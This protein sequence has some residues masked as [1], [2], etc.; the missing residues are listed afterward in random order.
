MNWF[1]RLVTVTAIAAALL[2]NSHAAPEWSDYA[3]GRSRTLQ[4]ASRNAKVL[5]SL[6]PEST[7]LQFTNL[8][9]IE[10]HLTNQ[11]LLN[12]SGVAAGDVDGDGWCDVFFAGLAGNG[13]LYR[14]L[15]NWKFED[16]TDRIA[17]LPAGLEMSGVCLV[18]ADGDGDLD[19][20]VNSVGGGTW[21]LA[22][23]G[24]GRFQPFDVRLN[25]RRGGSSLAFGDIDGD[26][27]LDGYIANYRTVTIRDQ[28]NTR[29]SLREVQGRQQVVSV[30]GVPVSDPE[31]ANRFNFQI[32]A[33]GGRG[34]FAYDENGEADVLLRNDG[35]GHFVPVPFTGGAF[36][37]EAGRPL[38]APLFDW[39]LS[40]AFRDL[41]GD[42]APDLYVCN[43]FRSPD[44]LW[45]ND[46]QGRFRA[47][48]ALMLR[49]ISLSSMGVDFADV[50]RDGWDDFL[51]VDMLSRLHQHRFSQR[52]DIRPEMVGPGVIDQRMQYPRNTMFLGRGDGSFVQVA[53][54]SGLDATEWS[55]APV[56]LDVDLDGYEDLLVSNG[57]E[58]DGM[59]VDVLREIELAKRE[60]KMTSLEQLSLRRKFPRLA[61]ANL[62]F[63]NAGGGRFADVSAEWGFDAA[64][65]SQGMCLAD[66]D[67]D[68]DLDVL[69]N[70]MNAPALFYRNNAAGP[71][72]AVRLKGLAP[73]TRGIGARLKVTGGPVVQTQEMMSG[74]RYLSS[75]DAV[76]T[77]AAGAAPLRIEVTWRSGRT[78]VADGVKPNSICEI[79][80]PSASAQVP[81]SAVTPPEPLFVDASALLNHSHVEEPFDDFARQPT[82]SR[83]LSQ[84]GPGVCWTDLDGDG[85]DDLVIGSGRGGRAAVFR[86]NGKGRFERDSGELFSRPVVRD[87][88]GIV[89]WR[90]GSNRTDVLIGV[91]NYEDGSTNGAAVELYN[92]ANR[93][94][95]EAVPLSSS[96]AGPLALADVDG[97]GELDLFVGGR[98][99]PDGFPKAAVSA[100]FRRVDGRLDRDTVNA[101]VLGE[102]GMVSAAVF[103][104]LDNDG[105]PDL[106]LACDWGPLKV[107][108]NERGS[109]APWDAPVVVS[110]NG[111]RSALSKLTGWWNGV[112]TGDFDGDGRQDIIASNWGRNTPFEAFRAPS[113]Q[114]YHGVF[115]TDE[116]EQCI[117]AYAEPGTGRALPSW[118][119]PCR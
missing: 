1:R 12:G 97:N 104:D 46:G 24:R 76:R 33:E 83:R 21:L 90:T 31:L 62:A 32:T 43:D 2:T 35:G 93:S 118:A 7:G 59:N 111:Q 100:L 53:H 74:G 116:A 75:D 86:N 23:D 66:L 39:G 26:G 63:H 81:P 107:F 80:E 95:H 57:F 22:N 19:L 69:V 51:V 85:W 112:T 9:S 20:A 64:A 41:N 56:F 58:R 115:G 3:W 14:N 84:L 34:N 49:Q 89:A 101:V 96:S 61:T 98:V 29:F 47:A 71:R 48:P 65:V 6:A 54:M 13:R 50:N 52:I 37:D 99:V 4:V 110:T 94:M 17:G 10:R 28:P 87:Q 55:W 45:L 18:D 68:G 8:L 44:R 73:N 82:L 113:L 78:T 40:V 117:E 38:M 77:F 5:E 91:A 105:D 88:S 108:R 103:S 30:D 79:A 42:G 16:T 119:R 102:V 92:I 67:N 70:N 36:L 15:G 109:L 60:R 25:S 27:D 72:V 11:I 106:V 114:L